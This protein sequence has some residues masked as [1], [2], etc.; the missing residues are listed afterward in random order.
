MKVYSCPSKTAVL[1]VSS[2]HRAGRGADHSNRASRKSAEMS[3]R[4]DADAILLLI[5]VGALKKKSG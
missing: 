5:A 2:W 3:D 1:P 4:G